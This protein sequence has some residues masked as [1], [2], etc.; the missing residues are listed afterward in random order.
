[1]ENMQVWRDRKSYEADILM[2]DM[3]VTGLKQDSIWNEMNGFHVTD[4]LSVDVMHDMLEG[5]CHY[6]IT[7]IITNFISQQFFTLDQLNMRVRKHNFGHQN[8]NK[9]GLITEQ[10]L[11]SKKLKCSA[12]EM[13]SFIQHFSH[14]VGDLVPEDENLE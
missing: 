3:S 12:S 5:V 7:Q 1:M 6:D 10:M 14:I 4:N 2:N 9:I 13:L 8:K 11:I